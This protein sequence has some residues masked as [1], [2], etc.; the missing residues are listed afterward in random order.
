MRKISFGFTLVELLIVIIIVSVLA[1]IAIPK[2]SRATRFA[3]EA[4]LRQTLRDLRVAQQR[5]FQ[6]YAGYPND[7]EDLTD[8]QPPTYIWENGEARTVWGSRVYQGAILVQGQELRNVYIKD[9]VS[10]NNF[11]TTRLSSGELRIRSSA[12]GNDSSGIAFSTY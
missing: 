7:I 5:Y 10:G 3:K 6:L 8:P 9:P 11:N 4:A 2:M 1:A 12:T